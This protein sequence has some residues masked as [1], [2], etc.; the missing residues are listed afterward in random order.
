MRTHLKRTEHSYELNSITLLQQI[1]TRVKNVRYKPS[2]FSG[3][4]LSKTVKICI[5]MLDRRNWTEMDNEI[6]RYR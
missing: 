5:E 6:P 3:L 2:T 4:L 1:Y